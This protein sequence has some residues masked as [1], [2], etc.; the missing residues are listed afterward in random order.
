MSRKHADRGD[1]VTTLVT[2]PG[3][4]DVPEGVYHGDQSLAP[5]LGRSLS[6]SGMKTLLDCP[7][8]FAHERDHG[9]P[10]KDAYDLGS[11]VHDLVLHGG[12]ERLR[13][14][15][16]YDW[17]KKAD[18]DAKKAAHAAGLVPVNRAD[19]L[20][21]SRIARAVRAHPLAGPIFSQGKPE[22]S[23]YWVDQDTGITC[24]ARVD[25]VRDNALVDLKSCEKASPEAFA[26]SCAN[27]RY[28]MQASHYSEGWEAVTGQAL[29]FI[30]VAVEKSPPYLIGVYQL[31]SEAMKNGMLDVRKTKALYAECESA[32]VW[33]GYPIEVAQ[34]SLPR[35]AVRA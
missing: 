28:D 23:I 32:N 16:C 27:F 33:P 5:T 17:R 3:V 9:R 2:E 20:Q 18:Q 6:N 35:W 31:D 14:I 7:A 29:P 21:A 10:P 1:E 34:L 4:Y 19:L 13:V 12:D 22:Q 30:F 26:K 24:R 8:R 25:W 11:L 15:D